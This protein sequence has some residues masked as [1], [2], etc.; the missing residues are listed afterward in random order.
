M[1]VQLEQLRNCISENFCSLFLLSMGE[2]LFGEVLVVEELDVGGGL[3][4]LASGGPSLLRVRLNNLMLFLLLRD[5]EPGSGEVSP[6]LLPIP[7]MLRRLPARCK[8]GEVVEVMLLLLAL[9]PLA[10]RLFGE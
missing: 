8:I 4:K 7:M 3:N 5:E 1:E 6:L 9:P 2:P 10:V